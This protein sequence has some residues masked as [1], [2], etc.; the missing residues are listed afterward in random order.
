MNGKNMIGKG[1]NT[2]GDKIVIEV[3]I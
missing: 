2:N 1:N 3:R